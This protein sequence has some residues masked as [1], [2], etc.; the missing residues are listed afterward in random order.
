MR[1]MRTTGDPVYYDFNDADPEF[2]WRPYQLEAIDAI[3]EAQTCLVEGGPGSGKTEILLGAIARAGLR[4]GVVV[5]TTELLDQWVKRVHHRLQIP[6]DE[7]GIIGDGKDKI[8]PAITI[9]MQRSAL[10]RIDKLRS[11]FGFVCL[12]EAHHAAAN[13]FLELM[14]QF[15]AKYRIG[16]SATIKRQDLKH[17]LTHDLFGD[18]A[19]SIS[20]EDLKLMGYTAEVTLH[21]VETDFEYDYLNEQA[22]QEYCEGKRVEYDELNAYEKEELAEDLGLEPKGYPQYLTAVAKDHARNNLIYRHLKSE[23]EANKKCA[24]FTKRRAHC[25]K[26]RK[27]LQKVGMEVVIL[28]RG[29]NAADKRRVKADLARLKTGEVRIGIGTTI[30]EGVDMPAVKAGFITYRNA[31]NRG[32]LIQQVGRLERLFKGGQEADLYYFHDA[33]IPRFRDDISALKRVFKKVVIHGSE[34]EAA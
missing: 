3:M 11:L 2:E 23:Y 29:K 28:W 7:I 6:L 4:A 17:F 27:S 1:D 25:V 9:M 21:I 5:P 34:K 32:Q 18:I 12:D 8:G 26:W 16:A 33:R 30:D 15:D 24:I 10:S 14:D 22:L 31:Q 20:R 19:F 13:T